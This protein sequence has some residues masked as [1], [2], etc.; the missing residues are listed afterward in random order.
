M[1]NP[2]LFR[3]AKSTNDFTSVAAIATF[4]MP[5]SVAVPAL[6]GA[7]KTLSAKG[8]WRTFHAS[9]CS[10]PPFPIIKIFIEIPL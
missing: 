3:F 6:P 1:V 10:R 9:A 5:C 2:T 8:D 7:T 4:S